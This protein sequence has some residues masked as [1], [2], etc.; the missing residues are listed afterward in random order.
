MTGE[1]ACLPLPTLLFSP[2][3]SQTL[4]QLVVNSSRSCFT[5]YFSGFKKNF[6]NLK[7]KKKK[8]KFKK[9][10]AEGGSSDFFFGNYAFF[11]FLIFR[12]CL[13]LLWVSR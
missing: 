13:F 4:M 2:L 12:I 3:A 7:K 1:D 5:V 6:K 8:K 9:Q 10:N 11:F